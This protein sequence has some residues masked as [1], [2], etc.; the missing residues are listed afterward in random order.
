MGLN[1]NIVDF[2]NSYYVNKTIL[3]TWNSFFFP[4]LNTN[5]GVGQEFTLFSII[6]TIYMA[7]IIKKFKKRIKNL[8]DKIPTDILSFV[9]DGLLISQKSYEL[10]FSF[11]L[12]SY[13]IMSKILL[14]TGL[15]IEHDKSEV[16]YFTR[17][18]HPPNLPIDLTSVRGPILMPKPIWHYLDFYFSY[19]L[20]F[21]YYTHFYATK[22]LLTLNTIK[23][24]GNLSH[25]ILPLQ[26]QLLYRT[27]ILLIALYSFQL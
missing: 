17:S 21:H 11:L 16:F 5:I 20:N 2:F 14:D 12:C 3:Y 25:G 13:H 22:C 18:C 10:S 9:D 1:P 7:S 26:K 19:K 24:L 23:L 8:K 15:I 4:S 27:Y 6:S